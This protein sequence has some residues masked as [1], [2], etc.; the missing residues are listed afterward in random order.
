MAKHVVCLDECFNK[1]EN[2]V[3]SADIELKYSVNVS[4]IQL[5]N[6]AIEFDCFLTG[7]LLALSARY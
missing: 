7:F 2:N 1:L 4:E 5:I 3:Y 6:G